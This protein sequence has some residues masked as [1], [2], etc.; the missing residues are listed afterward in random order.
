MPDTIKLPL[1]SAVLWDM[2]GTLIDQ[3]AAI[4]RC[5]CDVITTLGY[6]EPD[7]EVIRRSLGGPMASTMSL[8]I[9]EDQQDQ[10]AKAFRARF[11]EIMFEGL[12]ILAGGSELIEAFYKARIP[13]AIFTNKHGDTAR[14]VSKYAGF[15]KHVPTCIGNTDTEWHKPQAELTRHVLDQI[16]ASAEGACMIGDSPTDIETAHNAGLPC[17]CVATGAH[18]VDELK[19]TGAEAAFEN[20]K[21]LKSALQL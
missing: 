11:P 18:S 9:P 17:Y 10:A 1:P 8:F 20:L 16:D 15:A 4:V 5:Y 19:A 6:P 13:Q 7:A 2:D 3:T 21:E 12:I 14:S